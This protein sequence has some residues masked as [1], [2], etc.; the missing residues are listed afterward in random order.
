MRYTFPNLFRSQVP[1]SPKA[2][3]W[4]ST[5]RRDGIIRIEEETFREIADYVDEIYFAQ[6][7]R[8]DGASEIRLPHPDL[9]V[10]DIN[11]SKYRE[12]G[13]EVGCSISFKDPRLAPLFFDP[14]L[15]GLLYNYYRRQPYYRNQPFLQ[16]ISYDG[17]T[18]P[19]TNFNWHVD[20]VHQ[21]SFML[22]VSNVT[23]RDTH[24]RYALGSHRRI[25]PVRNYPEGIVERHGFK[26]FDAIGPKGTLFVFDAGG[27]HRACYLG[28]TTRKILHLNITT[29][30]H[31][32][33]ER[34]DR[35]EPWAGLTAYP[36]HGRRMM[37]KIGC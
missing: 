11:P 12:Y 27:I 20:Y 25:R 5:L 23:L 10:K 17:K 13:T 30:H 8:P 3:G 6:M 9:F 16:K 7:D 31:T 21:M 14:D 29:G 1:A 35:L 15:T 18:P 34:Y 22:L 4:L 33:A 19:N 32:A 24:M 28:G 26:V 36:P 37:E 2:R